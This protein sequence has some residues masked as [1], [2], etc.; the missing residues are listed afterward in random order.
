MVWQP[1]ID[2]S[3]EVEGMIPPGT[4]GRE[5]MNENEPTETPERAQ[6]DRMDEDDVAEI[7]APSESEDDADIA[8]ARPAR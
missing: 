6:D 4:P 7:F 5:P 2:Q 3:I 1:V 8:H